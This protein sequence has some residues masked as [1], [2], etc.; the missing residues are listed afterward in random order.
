MARLLVLVEALV[1]EATL[2]R[3]AQLLV[4]VLVMLALVVAV[5]LRALEGSLV[6]THIQQEAVAVLVF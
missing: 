6:A 5:D 4:Q 3:A 2:V 1:L